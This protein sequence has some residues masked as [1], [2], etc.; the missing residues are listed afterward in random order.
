MKQDTGKQEEK[1]DM[2][3]HSEIL[4]RYSG[5]TEDELLFEKMLEVILKDVLL[6]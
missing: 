1:K 3:C 5:E 6:L 4:R 2:P